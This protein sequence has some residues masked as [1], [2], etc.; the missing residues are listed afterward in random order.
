VLA[1]LLRRHDG[2]SFCQKPAMVW[3]GKRTTIGSQK[4]SYVR[5][6]T[7]GHGHGLAYKKGVHLGDIT[8]CGT[9]LGND[10]CRTWDDGRVRQEWKLGQIPGK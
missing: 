5:T 7:N 3:T 2:M 4:A 6:V 9:L 8:G 1:V 10:G